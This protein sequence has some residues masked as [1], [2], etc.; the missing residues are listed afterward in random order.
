MNA[1][2]TDDDAGDVGHPCL[3]ICHRTIRLGIRPDRPCIPATP[4]LFLMET[5]FAFAHQNIISSDLRKGVVGV[6]DHLAWN[7][8]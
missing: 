5:S 3:V 2:H 4:Q 7:G 8:T 1:R 6:D